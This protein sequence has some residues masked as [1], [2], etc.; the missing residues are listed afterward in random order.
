VLTEGNSTTSTLGFKN[1]LRREG[2]RAWF[3]LKLDSLRSET[4]DDRFVILVPGVE[5]MP[6]ETPPPAD[7][8][9]IE[10]ES[11]P[12]VE[13]Y[14]LEGRY[15]REINKTREWNVG[16]SWDR[17][18]DAGILNRYIVFAG[19]GNV[20]KKKEKLKFN[21]AYALSFT[22]R[23]EEEPD[24][25]KD[26]RF[27]G[28][29]LSWNLLVGMGKA[30][31]YKNDFVSNVSLLDSSDYSLDMT[32]SLSVSLS[33]H[34]KLKVS[35]QWLF[36]GEP[37][38]EE[39]DLKA[40]VVLIDPDGVPGSGDEFFRTVE[41]GGAEVDIGD[42]DIRKEQLDTIFRTSLVINF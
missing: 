32:N 3:E 33:E 28:I 16:G 20:W 30:T 25:E 2:K 1:T 5:W 10:P 42:T 29:R 8:T 6:G 9:T 34:L 18:E 15:G 11:E 40:F 12:D 41:S 39:V 19:L 13:I 27:A 21:T 37:A 7:T 23:E 26:D 14:F 22:D 35:L 17:N 38:L 31:V 36:A 24:S 4:A